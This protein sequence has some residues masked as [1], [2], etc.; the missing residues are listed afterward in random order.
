M[1]GASTIARPAGDGA[2]QRPGATTRSL[3][4]V[5]CG[6]VYTKVALLGIIEERYRLIAHAKAPTTIAAPVADV[7]VG[8]RDAIADIE[9]ATGRVLLR[10]GQLVTPERDDGM[11]VDGLSLALSVSGP[12]RVLTAGPGRDALAGLVQ[13]AVGGLFIQLEALPPTRPDMASGPDWQLALAQLRAFQPHALLV[14][15]LPFGATRG[16]GGIEETAASVARWLDGLRELPPGES[17]DINGQLPVIVSGSPQDA[18][19][20]EAAVRGRAAAMQAVEGLSPSAVGSLSRV[21]AS[22]YEGAVLR[23]LPNY[24]GLRAMTRVTPSATI[25]ALG[26]MVRYLS[27]HFQ[28]NV[29]GVDAGASSTS[30]V[31]ATAQGEI[32]P[33]VHPHAGVGPGAGHVLRAV[34]APA[35]LRWLSTSATEDELREH[36]LSRMLRRRALPASARELEF[37]YALAREAIGLALRAP[38]SRLTGL[39]A[40]DVVL[41]SGGVLANAPHPALAALLL[42]DALQPRGVT[43]LV[44]DKA[45]L[46]GALGGVAGLDIAAAADVAEGDA[47]QFQLGTVISPVSSLADGQ[48]ALRVVLDFPDGRQHAE[49]ITHGSLVRL[50]LRMGEQAMLGLYPAPTVDV[51]VGPGQQARAS[52]P[53]EGGALGLIVDARG[54]PFVLPTGADER[55]ARL[56][57][58]RHALGLEAL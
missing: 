52:E 32:L 56:V 42:L 44:L 27:Q 58:W 35:V 47:V 3:L 39:H 51:G 5:D 54:R 46:A 57:Q 34:G 48:P 38:G 26:G 50:P 33:A 9:R 16:Q 20:V 12:L 36:V 25:T 7:T 37:E 22:L 30:L 45:Q 40:M 10:D 4:I 31:G 2:E 43:A 1:G 53:V 19:V 6:S 21:V 41:G 23:D 14:I 55:I 8:V 49:E 28:T 29:I 18:G 24:A 15:G 11:G 17:S 13:R